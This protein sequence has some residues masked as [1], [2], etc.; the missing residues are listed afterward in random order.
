ML[1]APKGG[2]RIRPSS[3]VPCVIAGFNAARP[4][5]RESA[6]CHYDRRRRR[7]CF[8]AA[9]PE[10]RESGGFTLPTVMSSPSSFNAARPERRESGSRQPPPSNCSRRFNAARPEGRES[11]PRVGRSARQRERASMLPAP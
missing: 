11:G 6:R 9:R 5:G 8:N 3:G 10:G 4:E 2:S 1:P 7:R